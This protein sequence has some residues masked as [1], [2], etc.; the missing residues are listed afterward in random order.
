M[1]QQKEYLANL[2][3]KKGEERKVQTETDL[4]IQNKNMESTSNLNQN[5]TQPE[6]Q[7][8]KPILEPQ[9]EQQGT[10]ENQENNF[11]K[12]YSGNFR[13][14]TSFTPRNPHLGRAY[15]YRVKKNFKDIYGYDQHENFKSNREKFDYE[16]KDLKGNKLANDNFNY[17]HSGAF[18]PKKGYSGFTTT[19]IPRTRKKIRPNTTETTPYK[20]YEDRLKR[21]MMLSNR[22]YKTNNDF[23]TLQKDNMEMNKKLKSMTDRRFLSQYKLPDLSS[24][25]NSKKRIRNIRIGNSKEMGERYNPYG[26]VTKTG[27]YHGRNFVGALFNH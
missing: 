26:M 23:E 12:T 25:A 20:V 19:S 13:A 5:I 7:S 18:S 27:D 21:S 6:V 8:S 16:V 15:P 11:N 1:N 4:P 10:F 22:R 14:H 3:R 24:I 17:T 2:K 9:P